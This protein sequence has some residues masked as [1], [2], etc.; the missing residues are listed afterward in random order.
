M[1]ADFHCTKNMKAKWSEH[2]NNIIRYGKWT[3]G[4]LVVPQH[5]LVTI[6]KA[7]LRINPKASLM[8]SIPEHLFWN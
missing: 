7:M 2:K 1:T 3:D 5:I 8:G 4:Q 6:I